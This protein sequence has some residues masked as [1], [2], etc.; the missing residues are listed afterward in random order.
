MIGSFSIVSCC[1]HPP[2]ISPLHVAIN[3]ELLSINI[4]VYSSLVLPQNNVAIVPLY[5]SGTGLVG[6]G[7][8]DCRRVG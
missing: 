5:Q 6:G 4:S 7:T 2:V 3:I 1:N 8:T